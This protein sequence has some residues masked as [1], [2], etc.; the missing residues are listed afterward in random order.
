M[1]K[2]SLTDRERIL[3]LELKD[4]DKITYHTLDFKC[5]HL[6]QQINLVAKAF[7]NNASVA[8]TWLFAL[9]IANIGIILKLF[10]QQ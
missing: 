5:H 1:M 6:E 3:K 2:A 8:V 10:I 4:E 7:S 9:T